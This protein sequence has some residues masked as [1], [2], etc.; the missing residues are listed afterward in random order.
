[1]LAEIRERGIDCR[2]VMVTA[3]EP[4]FDL[5][6]MGFDAY[7]T[8]PPERQELIDTIETLLDRE[9]LDDALQ[10]YHSLM[11]RKAAIQAQKSDAELE[12][13]DAYQDLLERIE[14]TREETDQ[15]L[16]DMGSDIDF[17]SAVRE[18]AER[19]DAAEE[20]DTGGD[21]PFELG[22]DSS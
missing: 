2:V 12:D 7:V 10:E 4:D 22:V 21:D 3:V 14:A 9:G 20:R 8:K 5:I 1:V 17:V 15:K 11:A 18:I 6:E 19:E 16:G 13:S